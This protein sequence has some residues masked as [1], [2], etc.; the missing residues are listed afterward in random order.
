LGC[1]E[2]LALGDEVSRGYGI[3]SVSCGWRRSSWRSQLR[4]WQP[5]ARRPR[6]ALTSALPG[7]STRRI[8]C[9]RCPS[10]WRRQRARGR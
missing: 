2:Q 10:R 9:P 8:P 4:A 3:T 6:P 5:A 1:I 7:T